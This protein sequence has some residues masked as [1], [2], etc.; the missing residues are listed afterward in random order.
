MNKNIIPH[1][2]WFLIAITAFAV[3]K[4]TETKIEKNKL[5]LNEQ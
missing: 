2:I 3:G 1:A 4:R 5:G